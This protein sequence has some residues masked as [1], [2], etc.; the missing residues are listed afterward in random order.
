MNI[1]LVSIITILVLLLGGCAQQPKIDKSI[2]TPIVDN[3]YK[4]YP[5]GFT[6]EIE[7]EYGIFAK[8]TALALVETMNEAKDLDD[9]GKMEKVN[10]FFNAFPYQSDEK[11]WGISDYWATRLEFIGKAK[12]TAKI[13]SSPNTLLSK[14]LVCRLPSSL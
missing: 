14:S 3:S 2:E 7:K 4:I 10:D 11:I 8:R 5:Q 12:V 1:S 9:M 13:M 6:D